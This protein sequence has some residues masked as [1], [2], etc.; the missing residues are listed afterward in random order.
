VLQ[1]AVQDVCI[2]AETATTVYLKT[3]VQLIT[4]C[5]CWYLR[6]P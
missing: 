1:G 3:F 4:R 6:W 5:C 2:S